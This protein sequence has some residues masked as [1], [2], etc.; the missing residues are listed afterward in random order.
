MKRFQFRLQR[1]ARVRKV[2]EELA[3][4][5]FLGAEHEARA[6]EESRDR[7][8]TQIQ[9]AYEHLR[10]AQAHPRVDPQAVLDAS[11]SIDLMRDQAR[12]L[13]ELARAAREVAERERTPWQEVRAELEGLARLEDK[14]RKAHR[15]EDEHREA[16]ELD[17]TAGERRRRR[18]PFAHRAENTSPQHELN[19]PRS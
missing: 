8:E 9:E 12:V 1:L 14:D 18:A 2:Q 19:P 4:A 13:G 10:Q 5:R 7:L 6:R 15:L 16:K 3:R 11:L 17:E